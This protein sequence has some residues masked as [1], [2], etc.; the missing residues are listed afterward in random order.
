MSLYCTCKCSQAVCL[1]AVFV[2]E[3]VCFHRNIL[4]SA[5]ITLIISVCPKPVY[6]IKH[7]PLHPMIFIYSPIFNVFFFSA[8]PCIKKLKL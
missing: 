3:I 1:I 7:V 5:C 6:M 8:E 2:S 4:R